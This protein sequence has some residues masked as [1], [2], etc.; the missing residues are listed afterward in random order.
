MWSVVRRGSI[1]LG[2]DRRIEKGDVS[3]SDHNGKANAEA[4][5]DSDKAP[6]WSTNGSRT[7]LS[8]REP[9][10]RSSR[11]SQDLRLD[12]AS[13]VSDRVGEQGIGADKDG[14][15]GNSEDLHG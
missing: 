7:A 2:I 10:T 9:S 11:R 8:T 12:F 4:A 1:C 6:W 5:R 13:S 14:S 15:E 3:G